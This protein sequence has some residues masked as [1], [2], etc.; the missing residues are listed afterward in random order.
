MVPGQRQ[1]SQRERQEIWSTVFGIPCPGQGNESVNETD[2]GPVNRLAFEDVSDSDA[3]S[4]SVLD[5]YPSE[6]AIAG[7]EQTAEV[8]ASVEDIRLV[9]G[10]FPSGSSTESSDPQNVAFLHFIVKRPG[11][12]VNGCAVLCEHVGQ[13]S[14]PPFQMAKSL[15]LSS[16]PIPGTNICWSR[17]HDPWSDPPDSHE[18]KVSRCVL[19]NSDLADIILQHFGQDSFSHCASL[20]LLHAE[21]PGLQPQIIGIGL[22][23]NRTGIER[24]AYLGLM[25]AWEIQ[26]D[27]EDPFN[28]SIEFVSF[29]RRRAD[30]ASRI[31]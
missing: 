11:L 27:K 13:H 8:D 30:I 3:K 1:L 17:E 7:L 5:G 14:G 25:A 10:V 16:L 26:S 24:A 6:Y 9:S 28:T 21:Q 31:S 4:S 19:D 12:N 29:V 18:S 23:R 20:R 22:G 2:H 15:Y